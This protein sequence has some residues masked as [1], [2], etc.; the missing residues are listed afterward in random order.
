M[1]DPRRADANATA[2]GRLLAAGAQ[3]VDVDP[4]VGGARAGAGHV[5]A[6]RPADRL[7]ARVRARCAA[8]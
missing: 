8:R 3:L 1:A 5:P 7:G 6:R 2:V 4:A